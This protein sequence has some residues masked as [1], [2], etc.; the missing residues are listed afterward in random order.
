MEVP[1]ER[2]LRKVSQWVG[3]ADEDL[4]LAIYALKMRGKGRAFRLI[5]YHAQQCAEKHLKAFLVY[6][7]VDFPY[8]HNIRKLLELCRERATWPES[9]RDAEDLTQYAI[10]ARYP[11]ED[12]PITREEAQRAVEIAQRVRDQVRTALEEL[13]VELPDQ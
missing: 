11:G 1:N 4:R 8:T 12:E 6:H 2:L 13:G 7:R 5:A 10:T 3:Y 9:L